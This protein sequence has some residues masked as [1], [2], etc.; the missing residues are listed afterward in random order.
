MA[1]SPS[2]HEYEIWTNVFH[3]WYCYTFH[4]FALNISHANDTVC[5]CN[6]HHCGVIRLLLAPGKGGYDFGTVGLF[7]CL[8]VF[9]SVCPSVGHIM[10][11][12]MNGL[13]WNFM[14]GFWGGKRNKWL[15]FGSD[16]YHLSWEFRSYNTGGSKR[17]CNN[18]HFDRSRCISPCW[19]PNR[20]S[21]H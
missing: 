11:K 12:V 14:D 19:L 17:L 7:V 8:S 2:H 1:C 9:L 5:I 4:V 16:P 3:C 20:K 21:G 15:D 6:Y 18:E 10:Q 13:W